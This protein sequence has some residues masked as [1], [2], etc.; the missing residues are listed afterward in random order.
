[1]FFR[2]IIEEF[3]VWAKREDRKPLVLRGARQVGKTTAVKMFAKEFDNFIYLN[4]EKKE[5]VEIFK[6][7][8]ST[9]QII[10]NIILSKNITLKKGRSLIFIDEI[11][12]SPEAVAMLRYFY[13]S[14]PSYHVIA[15]GSLLEIM[16]AKDNLSFPVGRVEY[17]FMYPLTFMEFLLAINHQQALKYYKMLP[18]PS[19]AMV[20]IKE[21][22]HRYT[23]I[24]GMPE[25][26]KKYVETERVSDLTITYQSLMTSYL[27]DVKKYARNNS[28]SEIIK[29][30]I[31]SSPFEAGSR[32]KFQG[33]GN[34]NY[35]SRE[36]GEAL[37]TMQRAMLLY[38]IYPTTSTKPPALPNKK[39][40]PRLQFVDTG[41]LNFSVGLHSYFFKNDDLHS[42]YQGKLAEHIVGQE[43]IGRDFQSPASYSFW[44]KEKKQ[45]NAEVDFIVQ[46]NEYFIPIEIKSGVSGRLRSL[47]EFMDR[48][49]HTFAIRM[50]SGELSVEKVKTSTGK[51]YDLLNLPYCFSGVLEG[52][53][54]WFLKSVEKSGE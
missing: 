36:I 52:Y 8:Y 25:I 9:E 51:E 12:N 54:E 1:M 47:H 24:G 29:H 23:M 14:F 39:K 21:L 28:M 46:H 27:D 30:A 48:V 41:L 35:K 17:R 44:V 42:I 7:N 33:F 40:S 49:E 5:D 11:Q 50:Y 45:S 6:Q 10:D 2:T 22:F 15:A 26:V 16:M 31:E 19:F 34:S 32:I 3:R 4:L 18:C 38:L 43:L 37:R 20:K 13:E 53:L